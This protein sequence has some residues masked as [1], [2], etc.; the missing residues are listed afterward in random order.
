[1]KKTAPL[2]SLC[3]IILLC[4]ACSP[5]TDVTPDEAREIA[6]EAYIYGFPTVV[7]YKTMYLYTLNEQSPEY[8][9]P[10]NFVGCDAR[11]LTP[12]DKAV[13]TPNADT[14]YCMFW[15]D[16]RSEPVI[17]SLPEMEPERFYH[18][19]LIDLN[20]HNF[21][22]L[23][24]LSTGNEAGSYMI[25]GPDFKGSAPEGVDQVIPCETDLFFC[26]VRTQLMDDQDL[27]NVERLQEQ[28]KLEPLSQYLGN[29][30]P[31]STPME[32]LPEWNE[33]DQF[34]ANSFIYLDAMLRHMDPVSEEIMLRRRLARI[35]IGSKEG[36]SLEKFDEE[37]KKAIEEGVKEGF[38]EI[39]SFLAE[40]NTDPLMSG[41][42]F[43]TREFLANSAS[44]NFGHS[45]LFLIRAAAAHMGLYGNSGDEAMY[46]AYLLDSEGN[47]LN[48]AANSY[49]ITFE[50]G[51]LP[52]VESF[53][54]VT[55]Y[56]APT[57]LFIHNSLDRYLLNSNS[58]DNFVYGE[59]G[60]LTFYL[61]KESPGP[62]LESNWLPAP[63]GP[64]YAVMRLYGPKEEVLNG[65]WTN[66]PIVKSN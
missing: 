4:T 55:M 13:V 25:T 33:G 53:W 11:L 48:A 64:F 20:T 10:L 5:E 62:E 41:K 45:D 54:S 18:F 16:I 59:D 43:G 36:F 35:G 34:T 27:A 14:P 61:T 7:N 46:P 65:E 49:T 2:I 39:E 3:S 51:N 56:D 22:Y 50:S 21:A 30:V 29:E 6:R 26:V 19:Q 1:M 60:S 40:N 37:V 8:K 57:Q 66:P 31:E 28:Y 24:T 42:I 9:G 47:P 15:A 52:P 12:E 23:G 58:I 17:I 32:Q 38:E 63:D 44:T